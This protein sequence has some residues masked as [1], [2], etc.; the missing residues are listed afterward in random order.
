MSHDVALL[1]IIAAAIAALVVLIAVLKLNSFIA[2]TLV[3]LAAG[4][5]AGTSPVEVALAF[6]KGV[7]GVLSSIAMVIAL[8]AVLGKML[9]VSGGAEEIASTL[10]SWFG[11][12]QQALVVVLIAALV[13]MP[14]FFSVGV[15]LLIPVVVMLANKSALP[16]PRLGLPLVTGLSISHCFVPPH[17]GPMAAVATLHADVGK[18]IFLSLLISTPLAIVMGMLYG[19]TRVVSTLPLPEDPQAATQQLAMHAP[20]FGLTL[21]TLLLPVGFML[22]K[23]AA[24]LGLESANPLRSAMMFLGDPTVA[25]LLAVM[26]SFWSLGLR[27][28]ISCHQILDLSNECLAP[29]AGI[30]LVIAAGGGFKEVLMASKVDDAIRHLTEYLSLSPMMLTW[31]IAAVLRVATGSS[32]VAVTAAAG[33]VAP[34]AEANPGL[35]RELLVL[36]AGAGSLTL[37]HLNDGGF[38]LVQKYLGLSVADTLRTW[39]VMTTLTSVL[40]L[41]AILA[42]AAMMPGGDCGRACAT[43][44]ATRRCGRSESSYRAECWRSPARRS[45]VWPAAR[46]SAASRRS[47][48]DRRGIALGRS[49][50]PDPCRWRRGWRC[51]PIGRRGRYGRRP[52]P[53]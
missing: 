29:V 33:L 3:S 42:I 10:L 21:A 44:R 26:F 11:G 52:W 50:H 28:G 19:R 1:L 23:T 17:P 4:L 5:A 37:S 13:G 48:R 46:A 18:T 12:R 27:L 6:Q 39:T 31:L 24:E 2:L 49:R 34:L 30:L 9:A 38:W 43:N 35:N 14:V 40:A 45:L 22:L 15:V 7:G 47:Y 25:M 53:W 16:L 8:G 20:S 36:S 41:I 51:R 32:T